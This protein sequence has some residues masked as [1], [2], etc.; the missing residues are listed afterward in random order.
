MVWQGKKAVVKFP[1]LSFNDFRERFHSV[2][3]FISLLMIRI[4]KNYEIT[5]IFRLWMYRKQ[6]R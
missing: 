6:T 4:N 5:R 2:P 1:Y 3:L